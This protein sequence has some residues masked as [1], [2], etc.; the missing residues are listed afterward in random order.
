MRTVDSPI[1]TIATRSE[2]I[3]VRR[4]L[5]VI[6]AFAVLGGFA[7]AAQAR[8]TAT[9]STFATVSASW[10]TTKKLPGG[11]SRRTEWYI[12]V[13]R[14]QGEESYSFLTRL[15]LR[16]HG[17]GVTE[18][19]RQTSTVAGPSDLSGQTFEM[20]AERP[21][22]AHLDATYDLQAYDTQGHPLGRQR[23]TRFVASWT[24][25]GRVERGRDTVIHRDRC[26]F[27][28]SVAV[29]DSQAARARATVNGKDLGKSSDASVG[30]GHRTALERHAC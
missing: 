13:S 15:I 25:S 26:E 1:H 29:T 3:I 28:R 22:A 4:L 24:G 11:D 10:S 5:T 12:D 20:D 18:D 8:P 17:T 21:M 2:D 19:C 16:C 7:A 27:S 14:G 9:R 6:T 30:L 23:A